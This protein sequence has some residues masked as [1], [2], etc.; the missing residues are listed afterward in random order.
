[1]ASSA[2][3]EWTLISEAGNERSTWYLDIE[4]LKSNKD[5]TYAWILV[6]LSIPLDGDVFST[7]TYNEVY[8]G[9]P[10][11]IKIKAFIRYEA[12]M[13]EGDIKDQWTV[14]DQTIDY[15]PPDSINE[16]LVST[17]CALSNS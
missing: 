4:A 6:D 3:A 13:G 8:C 14:E 17:I 1:M 2:W 5:F 16:E 7:K 15:A 9:V 12:R 10:R 11:W